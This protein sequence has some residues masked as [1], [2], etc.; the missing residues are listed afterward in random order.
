MLFYIF[1]TIYIR[2]RPGCKKFVKMM[3]YVELRIDHPS[4]SLSY[5]GCRISLQLLAKRLD[6]GFLH[7]SHSLGQRLP[8]SVL[9]LDGDR[10]GEAVVSR[11]Q[12]VL[13]H[14]RLKASVGVAVDFSDEVIF[15]SSESESFGESCKKNQRRSIRSPHTRRAR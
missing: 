9:L 14:R 7:A 6:G 11:V 12:K 5:R 13:E 2:A 1:F 10:E 4:V 15:H 3:F 8:E